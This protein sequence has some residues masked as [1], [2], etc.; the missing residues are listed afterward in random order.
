MLL[1]SYTVS[2]FAVAARRKLARS[3][4]CYLVA[5]VVLTSV[6]QALAYARGVAVPVPLLLAG[7]CLAIAFFLALV[8][9]SFG[10]VELVLLGW[11]AGLATFRYLGVA[12]QSRPY[13]LGVPEHRTLPFA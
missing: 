1:G 7:I 2:D 10:R 8:V 9:S 4:L 3:A 13:G 12:H 11:T 5:L 6:V